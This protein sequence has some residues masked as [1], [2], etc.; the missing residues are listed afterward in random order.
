MRNR[1]AY[2]EYQKIAH[3]VIEYIARFEDELKAIWEKPK[4][5]VQQLCIDT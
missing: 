3:K 4:F 1:K 5:V 2:A